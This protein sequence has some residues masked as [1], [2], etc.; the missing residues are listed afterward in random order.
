LHFA[1]TMN[2]KKIKVVKRVDADALRAAGR[3]RKKKKQPSAARQMI[4]NVTTW[5][6]DV[7]DRNA[8]D[9]KSAFDALFTTSTEPTQA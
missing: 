2:E 9:A 6:S 4:T 7:K 8:S 3:R 5:V 1:K